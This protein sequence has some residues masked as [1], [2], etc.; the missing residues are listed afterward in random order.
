MNLS[1][2]IVNG[3]KFLKTYINKGSYCNYPPLILMV[4]PTNVCNI[5]CGMCP[6]GIMTREKGYMSFNLYKR[7][8]DNN[9]D[10][11]QS[12]NLYVMGE[13]LLNLQLTAMVKYAKN[14]NIRTNI[15]T[16]GTL[17]TKDLSRKLIIA[18][19]DEISV[20][21]E[22]VSCLSE[23]NGKGADHEDVFN[24]I[25]ML[26][27]ERNI[28]KKYLP[29]LSVRFLNYGFT[30]KEFHDWR[31]RLR[32][33]GVDYIW[34]VPMHDW[35]GMYSPVVKQN[36]K[37]K[38]KY[39][40]CVLPWGVLA[41]LWNGQVVGCCDDFD[42]KFLVG[43]INETPKL[44]DIWNNDK[45]LHLRKVLATRQYQKVD[46]CKNCAR[47]WLS[48]FKYPIFENALWELIVGYHNAWNKLRSKFFT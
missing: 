7:L 28:L 14:K 46:I 37:L 44:S 40:H 26:V 15:F 30:R 2:K 20:S 45:M 22:C 1:T 21:F 5:Q 10:F 33:A 6:N 13:P 36:K 48:P 16:N 29:L 11:I 17:L 43:D 3:V 27:R 32:R 19:T 25:K 35:T 47:L 18:G 31:K 34:K 38:K 8:I 23:Y 4:E 41:V 24:N 42:G 39:F 9:N 12:L